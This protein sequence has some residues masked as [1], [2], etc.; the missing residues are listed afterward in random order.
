[1]APDI[2][3]ERVIN[4]P[5]HSIVLDPMAGSGTVLREADK[6]GLKAIG[7]DMDPLAVLIARVATTQC[8]SDNL[9]C[10]AEAIVQKAEQI[11][12]RKVRLDWID[13]DAETSQFV[14]FWFAPSQRLQLRKLAKIFEQD[15]DINSRPAERNAL[16][17]AMSRII[18][19]KEQRASLARDT[20]RSRPHKVA[21]DNN[22]DVFPEF[23]RS[24][25]RLSRILEEEAPTGL[26]DVRTGDA[27]NMESITDGTID[28]VITSP[29]YLNAIDYLRG[30]KMS[31]VWM[32]HSISGLRRIRTDSVGAERRPD[33]H[34]DTE[35]VNPILAAVGKID[36]LPSR[37][38]GMIKRYAIDLSNLAKELSR[39]VRDHGSATFVVGNSCLREIP[40]NNAAGLA[41]AAAM[42][43]FKLV[44]QAERQLPARN[45]SLPFVKN[46]NNNLG[47]RMGSEHVMVFE[48]LA[49]K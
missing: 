47:K 44:D 41:S 45:R 10:L 13:S 31:L 21:E 3:L 11:D 43:G 5:K 48:K 28:A 35:I 9:V 1:M 25:K 16:L 8:E 4:L 2:A 49:A 33:E 34:L 26:A 32:G 46:D 37:Y 23:V 7:F 6:A 12:G 42:H 18:V 20:S 30:H 29:P 22:F 39:V 40:I 36:E 27:R 24:A 19:T 38:Q 17:L 15:E 14:K